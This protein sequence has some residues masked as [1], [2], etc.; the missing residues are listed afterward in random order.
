M[1]AFSAADCLDLWERGSR[2][3]PLDRGLLALA[4]ALPG[5]TPGALADW[6]LGRRNRAL[7]ELRC[8]CFGARMMA[9]TACPACGEKLE[10]EMDGRTLA[11]ER[12]PLAPSP[13]EIGGRRY[14]PPTTRDLAGLAREK[15]PEHAAARLLD[16]CRVDGEPDGMLSDEDLDEIGDRL[17]MADPMAE[18]RLA[19]QCA[20]CRHEWIESLDWIEFLWTE[21]EARARRALFEIHSLAAA[22][23]WT[24]EQIL[25]L[26]DTRRAWYV[27]MVQS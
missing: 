7:A 15:Q 12:E 3:H 8:A 18:T 16:V 10:F 6:P 2:L 25:A 1:R 23:G 26:S 5:A 11:A 13:V 20:V 17:A 9:W 22:Y 4:V 27:E 24:Q 14:R 19:L 21:I